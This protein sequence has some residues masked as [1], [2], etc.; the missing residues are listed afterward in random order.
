M[1]VRNDSGR[2]DRREPYNNPCDAF[3]LG[4]VQVFVYRVQLCTNQ[5]E[6]PQEGTKRKRE[7]QS[8]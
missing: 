8:Q 1:R 2:S 6:E 5:N 4:I 3:H 7:P